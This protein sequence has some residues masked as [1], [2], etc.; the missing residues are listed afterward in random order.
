MQ[1]ED[2][3][4][5]ARL[6]QLVDE[7]QREAFGVFEA[8]ERQTEASKHRFENHDGTARIWGG[9]TGAALHTLDARLGGHSVDSYGRE[10]S[11][12]YLS[13]VGPRAAFSPDGRLVVTAGD[14]GVAR[15]WEAA[16]G[17]RLRTL[18]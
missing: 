15:I 8:I 13:T 1:T 6:E 16:S 11:G 2:H 3:A 12:S 17:R 14:D 10:S 9:R 4:R 7:M 5:I 18:S